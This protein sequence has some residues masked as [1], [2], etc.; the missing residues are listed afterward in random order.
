[1][2]ASAKDLGTGHTQAGLAP[3][4]APTAAATFIARLLLC[5]PFILS[6][7][8]KLLDFPGAT[9]EVR[10]LTGLEPA[11]IFA[12]LVI[13]TQ[14]AGSAAILAGGRL[15]WAG[16]AALAAFTF[17]ATLLAHAYWDKAGM[18][19]VRDFNAFWEHVGLI[20]GLMLAAL[21]APR[22]RP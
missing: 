7:L 19:R 21:I 1:M 4:T 18:D 16:A 13:L 17:V 20:G 2:S 22:R 11:P 8:F 3:P 15:A 6:G 9:A 5:L 12:G 10:G 14:L